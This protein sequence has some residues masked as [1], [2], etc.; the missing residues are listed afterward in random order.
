MRRKKVNEEKK[1]REAEK[2]MEKKII[3]VGS[4][5]FF[6]AQWESSVLGILILA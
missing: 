5:N 6:I 3:A 4:H 2:E 1:E